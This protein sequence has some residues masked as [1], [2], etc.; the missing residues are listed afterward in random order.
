MSLSKVVSQGLQDLE[1]PYTLYRISSV[2]IQ[3]FI[4]AI[5]WYIINN[6]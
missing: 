1:N 3:D 4:V 2:I 6:V 5:T